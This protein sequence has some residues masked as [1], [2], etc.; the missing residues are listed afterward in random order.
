MDPTTPDMKIRQVLDH[1]RQVGP[2]DIAR[3]MQYVPPIETDSSVDPKLVRL[4]SGIDCL[5]QLLRHLASHANDIHGYIEEV[6]VAGKSNP[7]L[8]YAWQP[9]ERNQPWPDKEQ[10]AAAVAQK[11]EVIKEMVEGPEPREVAYFFLGLSGSDIMWET[12]WSRPETS[13]FAKVI[14]QERT[15]GRWRARERTRYDFACAVIHLDRTLN[16]SQTLQGAV[17]SSFGPHTGSDG[18]PEIWLAAG[19]EVARVFYRPSSGHSLP[20]GHLY[21]FD[22]PLGVPDLAEA[23]ANATGTVP[24]R[25]RVHY[26]LFAVIRQSPVSLFRPQGPDYIRTYNHSGTK[27]DMHWKPSSIVNDTW[28]VEDDVPGVTYTL[29]YL[30]RAPLPGLVPS[31]FGVAA[32][33]SRILRTASSSRRPDGTRRTRR[34]K[35]AGASKDSSLP[36]SSPSTDPPAS[37]ST[38]AQTFPPEPDASAAPLDS[39]LAHMDSVWVSLPKPSDD[40]AESLADRIRRVQADLGDLNEFYHISIAPSRHARLQQFY[41]DELESLAAVDFGALNQQDRIDYILLKKH[42]QR[43]SRQ[44]QSEKEAFGDFKVLLPFA[45]AIVSLCE[46][47]ENVKPMEAEKTAKQLD[48]ITT[49][50]AAITKQVQDGKVKISKT[51]AYRASKVIKELRGHLKEFYGFYSSYDPLFDWWCAAQWRAADA[52]LDAYLPLVEDKLAGL[53]S[54]GTGDIIGEPIGRKALLH[55]LEA[56]VLAY[57]PEELVR[58]ANEQ[59]RWCEAE[60]RRASR[61]LGYGDDWKR[62]MEYVKTKSVPPGEQTQLVL[63]L[64]REGANFVREHDLVTVPPIAEETYRMFMMSPAAQ[65]VNPFFLGGP[66]I[67]VS[68]PTAEMEYGLKQMVMRGNNRHFSKAT[69]FHELI[70]G[71]RLQLFMGE[72]HRSHRQLFQTPFFVEGWAMYWELVFWERGD[73]FTSAEDRIGTLFWRMHRCARIILSLGFHLGDMQPQECIDNL[74]AWVGH[75][76]STAEG[77][78]RRWLNGDYSPLYQCGY[79][80]GA[81]QLFALRREAVLEQGKMTERAFNDLVLRCGAIPQELVRAV[82]MET[83]LEADYDAKWRFYSFK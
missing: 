80:V 73:F 49:S 60:M 10:M 55:E 67:I 43:I 1:W 51:N 72:R 44:L 65:K 52:A 32:P 7:V 40:G 82:V 39:P 42:L 17:N 64:A 83:E 2:I 5:A 69:A 13:L 75:E 54:D 3:H 30:K 62:A 71:H 31:E 58:I 34:G 11:M 37:A 56:E 20:F 8:A 78:V 23:M 26:R 38:S 47:R 24:V 35:R 12:Y 28:S 6:M 77:E 22:L 4:T 33:A 19:A 61:E 57:S 27:V 29:V 68:Y 14:Y 46:R 15:S 45:D 25:W 50:V 74:V 53:R 21:E 79:F 76:R 63:E 9:F 41:D 48:G 66:A 36:G 70:P 18:L 59:F 16:S 81:L